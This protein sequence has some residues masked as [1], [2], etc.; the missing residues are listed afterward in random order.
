MKMIKINIIAVTPIDNDLLTKLHGILLLKM[1]TSSLFERTLQ[2]ASKMI[3]KVVV[4]IPP[5]K[6]LRD[7]MKEG[8]IYASEKIN[9]VLDHFFKTGN[10]KK[11]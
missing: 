9:Q 7:R 3:E 1:V 10:L 2:K 5:P 4:L 8:R 6:A 11:W